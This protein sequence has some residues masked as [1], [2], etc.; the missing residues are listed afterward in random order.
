[1]PDVR[2]DLCVIANNHVPDS[3]YAGLEDTLRSLRDVNNKNVGAGRNATKAAAPTT[4]DV[5]GNGRVL[6]FA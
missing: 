3:G 2:I 5:Y 1:M 6:V 4:K